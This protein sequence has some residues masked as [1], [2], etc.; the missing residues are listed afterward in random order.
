MTVVMGGFD[1]VNGDDPTKTRLSDK[2]FERQL[3]IYD[4]DFSTVSKDVIMDKSKGDVIAKA[5]VVFQTNWFAIQC[6][7]R[8]TQGIPVTELELTTLGHTAFI[9]FIY[10]FWWNKPLGVVYPLTLRAKPR[11]DASG[12]FKTEGRA[13]A[14]VKGGGANSVKVQ[15]LSWRI[16]FGGYLYKDNILEFRYESAMSDFLRLTF[17]LLVA[18]TFGAI[19]C[20][21]WNSDFPSR[22][23][24]TIWRA[25][26]LIV[27]VSPIVILAADE[28]Y[29]VTT[30]LGIILIGI[31][32][33]AR[34]CLLTVAFLSLRHLSFAAH[35]TLSWTSFLPHL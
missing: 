29:G 18:G 28:V 9:C 1:V 19:H 22:V 33:G 2:N 16:Q 4:I 12:K 20:L 30:P 17:I 26:T 35:Q 34:L 31:Y 25:S 15:S 5:L 21:G 23:E 3:E 32:V 13:G 6:I 10:F 7:T 24:Q 8:A 27:T 14:E 11:T